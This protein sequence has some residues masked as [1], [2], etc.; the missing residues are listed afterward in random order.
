MLKMQGLQTL[1]EIR[2]VLI[3][4]MDDL[5]TGFSRVRSLLRDVLDK[6]T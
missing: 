5:P 6:H 4:F 3:V 1:F 2:T